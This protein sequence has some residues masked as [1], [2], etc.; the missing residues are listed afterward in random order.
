MQAAATSLGN[1]R[2][3]KCC[4]LTGA[5]KHGPFGK[6]WE[7]LQARKADSGAME[8]RLSGRSWK[9]RREAA[10]ATNASSSSQGEKGGELSWL[11]FSFSTR[12]S[13]WLNITG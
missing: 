9:Q 1:G 7:I 12:A 10:T 4:V 3:K 8:E 11:P 6:K 13:Y 5:Q 2:I